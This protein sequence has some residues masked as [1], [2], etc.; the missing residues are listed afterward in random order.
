M[1]GF[2]HGVDRRGFLTVGA[3]G[4][5]GLSLGDFFRMR[6][7][8]GRCRHAGPK[9]AAATV[10]DLHL[11]A[12]RI[13]HQETF[14]P[15]PLRAGRIPRPAGQHRHRASRRAVRRAA[16]AHRQDRRQT[17]DLPLDDP[18]R[19]GPRAGHAQHVHGLP[20]EP[21]APV[22][23]HRLGDLPRVRPPRKPARLRL[24]P[25]RSPTSSPAR[26]TSRS[27][28]RASASAPIRPTPSSRSAT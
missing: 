25:Q 2:S 27:P 18:R 3:I 26:A 8:P 1:Q 16:P 21:G 24:H 14:D 12:R 23:E 6:G 19:G 13:A 22:S 20:A 10:G 11:S 28:T 7:S 9:E 4:G 5:L 17:G 15:K